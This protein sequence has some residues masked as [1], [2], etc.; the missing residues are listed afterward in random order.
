MTR[1]LLCAAAKPLKVT[2][3]I[4]FDTFGIDYSWLYQVAQF[5]RTLN[6]PVVLLAI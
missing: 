1:E 4:G 6:E 3:R 5:P 2:S